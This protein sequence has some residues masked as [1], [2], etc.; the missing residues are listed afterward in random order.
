M[1]I[2]IWLVI[3]SCLKLSLCEK[4]V[5]S[6]NITLTEWKYVSE[7]IEREVR[8]SSANRGSVEQEQCNSVFETSH[9]QHTHHKLPC[10]LGPG[11]AWVRPP[12]HVG[13]G[14]AGHLSH[15]SPVQVEAQRCLGAC[16]IHLDPEKNKKREM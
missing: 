12:P 7:H 11:L 10:T 3:L 16:H 8:Q 14:R 2:L 9:H 1:G 5:G 13:A 6:V 4:V 15:W